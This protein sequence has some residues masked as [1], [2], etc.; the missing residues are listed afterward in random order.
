MSNGRVGY[1]DDQKDPI[2]YLC[3]VEPHKGVEIN[4]AF[5]DCDSGDR[6][7][8]FFLDV[9]PIGLSHT[10]KSDMD[11]FLTGLFLMK[12]EAIVAWW[13]WADNYAD[14]CYPSPMECLKWMQGIV[15]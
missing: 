8:R 10:E 1:W 15:R 13:E 12:K 2:G 6:E 11:D 9:A 4:E 5:R 3:I 14:D 7:L